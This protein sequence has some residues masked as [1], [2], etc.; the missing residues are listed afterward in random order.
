MHFSIRQL[1][2]L[3]LALLVVWV[4]T[5]FADDASYQDDSIDKIRYKL[6]LSKY[7][8]NDLDADDLNFRAKLGNQ[9]VWLAY[10]QES[11]SN[12]EQFRTGYERTDQ[13]TRVKTIS[14][15]QIAEH[16]FFGGSIN[17]EVGGPL[18]AIIGYG[19]TNLRPY[20]N[21]NFDPNDSITYGIGWE[22]DESLNFSLYRVRDNRVVPG[23]QIDHFQTQYSSSDENKLVFDL[24]H[25]SG[26]TTS[27][28]NSIEAVGA[29]CSYEWARYFIR[30][31]YDPKVN[32]TQSNMTR[33]SLGLN[34]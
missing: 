22:K 15:I 20:D 28:G 5:A 12:F 11:P 1:L 10:Y 31:A 4:N 18:H 8:A 27:P 32:F 34:F 25:K 33:V 6:T 19:R 13:W 24:F 17:A 30:V 7:S 23:Q 2:K 14:S 9:S 26:P 29:A 16:G 21:I 3:T